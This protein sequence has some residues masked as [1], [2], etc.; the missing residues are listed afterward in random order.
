MRSEIID[1]LFE[2]MTADPW[3]VK[4]KR[5]LKLRTWMALCSTRKF[6]DRTFPGH[7]F[8]NNGPKT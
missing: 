5:W 4:F 2:G 1:K 3:H 6:W 8:K 7:V